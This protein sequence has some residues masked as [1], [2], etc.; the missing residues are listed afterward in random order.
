MKDWLKFYLLGVLFWFV[1][2]FTCTLFP[3]YESWFA[4]M[5]IIFIY[6]FGV[7]IIS[8]AFV[9]KFKWNGKKL[10]IATI[11]LGAFLEL[12]MFKN[13]L[14]L[15]FPLAIIFWII[16]ISIYCTLCFIPKW[17]VEKKLKKNKK[18]FIIMF[19][20]WLFTFIMTTIHHI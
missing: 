1:V 18:W 17:I 8:T 3:D 6:Y 4:L 11:I 5:P 12:V 14:L 7:P 20:I 16:A 2:D 10:L 15:Q 9:Y 19:A 13:I